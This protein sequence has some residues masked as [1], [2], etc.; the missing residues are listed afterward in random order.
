MQGLPPVCIS[1]IAKLKI[2][3]CAFIKM[4]ELRTIARIVYGLCRY[5]VHRRGPSEGTN[6]NGY[7]HLDTVLYNTYIQ[8]MFVHNPQ[9]MTV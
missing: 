7:L 9:L 1:Q 4:E 3:K 8:H 2:R 6:K 5:Y